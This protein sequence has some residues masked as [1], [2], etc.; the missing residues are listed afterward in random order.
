MVIFVKY[1][2]RNNLRELIF[3]I[4]LKFADYIKPKIF[5]TLYGKLHRLI[6]N[7]LRAMCI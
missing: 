2:T 3:A 1:I 4:V 7:L 5:C 6:I